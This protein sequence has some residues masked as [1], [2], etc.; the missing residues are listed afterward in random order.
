[1]LEWTGWWVTGWVI[2]LRLLWLLEH[3]LCYQ[4]SLIC[5]SHSSQVGEPSKMVLLEAMLATIQRDQVIMVIICLVIM[6]SIIRMPQNKFSYCATMWHKSTRGVR[7]SYLSKGMRSKEICNNAA[8]FCQNVQRWH[9]CREDLKHTLEFF[10]KT[11]M[12]KDKS[13]FFIS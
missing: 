1:M 4:S 5:F 11:K 12:S 3:L 9:S 2:P 7:E 13:L 8:L 6:V 10:L